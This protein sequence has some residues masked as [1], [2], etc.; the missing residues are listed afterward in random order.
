MQGERITQEL[1]DRE[2]PEAEVDAF[3]IQLNTAM[4]ID[5]LKAVEHDIVTA[6][7]P[8]P[9]KRQDCSREK[10]KTVRAKLRQRRDFFS[11]MAQA[12][13]LLMELAHHLPIPDFISLYAISK[14][15]HETV[16]GHMAHIMKSY[17]AYRARQASKIFIFNLYDSFCVDDPVG[18]YRPGTE[19]VRRVPSLRWVQMVLHRQRVVR[20]IL[21]CMAR[22]GHRMPKTMPTTLM[23]MWLTMDMATSARRVQFMHNEEYW[24]DNDIYNAQLFMIKLEMRFNDPIDGPGDDGLKKLM[25][26]QRGLTPLSKLL[27]RTAYTDPLEILECAIRY[28]YDPSEENLGHPI[29]GISP[30]DIGKG[31]LEGWGKGKVHLYRMDEIIPR[32]A[33]RRHLDLDKHMMNMLLWGYVDPITKQNIKVSDEEMYMSDEDE[34]GEMVEPH[35][36]MNRG[37][38]E[39]HVDGEQ[40]ETD[41][42]DMPDEELE[43][44]EADSVTVDGRE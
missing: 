19:I 20:D 21:A 36:E 44:D 14:E 27:K 12:P 8:H 24:T 5:R 40:W 32:E 39:L 30:H 33:C 3:G 11:S 1:D 28:S 18:R 4:L 15:F 23:K 43:E 13:E 37:S 2:K 34:A 10:Q 17:A 35:G 16:N 6:E 7:L 9:A 38:A 29:L 41:D 25:L 26:G 42:E 22:E 31:H